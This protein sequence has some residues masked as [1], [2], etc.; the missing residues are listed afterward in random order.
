MKFK[1]YIKLTC[2]VLDLEYLKLFCFYDR[3]LPKI[4]LT[5]ILILCNT[6]EYKPTQPNVYG[7]FRYTQV[8][9]K[10]KVLQLQL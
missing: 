7:T 10:D 2:Y 6:K 9:S 1:V 8:I 4:T 3:I 5:Y